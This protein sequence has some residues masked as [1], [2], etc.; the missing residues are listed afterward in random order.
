MFAKLIIAPLC[1]S[2]S[3][4]SPAAGARSVV[5]QSRVAPQAYAAPVAAPVTA[6]LART[7]QGA[8]RMEHEVLYEM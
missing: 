3:A 7:N 6:P 8:I 4:F 5:S 2:A 1:L